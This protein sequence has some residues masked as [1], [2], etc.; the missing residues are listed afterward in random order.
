MKELSRCIDCGIE[1]TKAFQSIQQSTIRCVWCFNASQKRI[2]R[3][4]DEC[5]LANKRELRR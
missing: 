3:E 5:A 1:L 2:R 4:L